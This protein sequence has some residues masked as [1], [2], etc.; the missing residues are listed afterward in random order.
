MVKTFQNKETNSLFS[1]AQ[2]EHTQFQVTVLNLEVIQKGIDDVIEYYNIQ[3]VINIDETPIN[4]DLSQEGSQKSPE[5]FIQQS[6]L[7]QISKK[8]SNAKLQ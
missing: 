4:Y 2:N 3:H 8:F 7:V 1:K 6:L 5:L